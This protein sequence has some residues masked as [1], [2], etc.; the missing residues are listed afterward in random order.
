MRQFRYS[1]NDIPADE[2]DWRSVEKFLRGMGEEGWEL[3]SYT[4][5]LDGGVRIILK[6]EVIA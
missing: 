1:V 4:P 6:K 2:C 3:V 5:A